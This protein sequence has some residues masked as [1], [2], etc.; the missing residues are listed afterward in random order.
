MF[1]ATQAIL[2]G[3]Q[4]QGTATTGP[5]LRLGAEDF[6]PRLKEVVKADPELRTNFIKYADTC[7][8]FARAMPSGGMKFW[9]DSCLAGKLD[10]MFISLGQSFEFNGVPV[11]EAGKKVRRLLGH[12]E[13]PPDAS[14][15]PGLVFTTVMRANQDKL[16]QAASRRKMKTQART[17]R[18]LGEEEPVQDVGAGNAAKSPRAV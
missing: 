7:A 11:V 1:F 13:T 18:V 8:K 12:A 4:H 3:L 6:Q 5:F 10:G 14:S 2:S 15:F 9:E 17:R 16:A